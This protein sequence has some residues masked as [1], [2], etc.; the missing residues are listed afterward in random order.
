MPIALMYHDVLDGPDAGASGFPGA[1]AA[2]YK[3][4]CAAF[5]DHLSAIARAVTAPPV[6]T[7]DDGGASAF[8]CI[9]DRLESRGWRGHFFITTDRIGAPGFVTADQ[10]RALHERGH[11][12]GSHSCSH[13]TRMAACSRAQLLREWRDSRALLCDL[14]GSS[15]TTA[16]VPGGYYSREVAAMAAQAG[17]TRLFTSEPTTRAHRVDGCEVLGRYTVLQTTTAAVAAAIAKGA[18]LPRWKQALSWNTKKLAK[19]AGGQAY[20]HLR[21]TWL[22]RAQADRGPRR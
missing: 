8:T 11:V 4:T 17:L 9:A 10:L 21:T 12:L 2:R 1:G 20:L 13:P 14:L 7:F 15:V 16:S 18:R 5:D 22:E 19:H 6:L 3:L